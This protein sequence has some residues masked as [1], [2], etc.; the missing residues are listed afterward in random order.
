MPSKFAGRPARPCRAHPV[1]IHYV[2]RLGGISC[3][4]CVPIA[5]TAASGTAGGG[6]GTPTTPTPAAWLMADLGVWVEC[7][8]FGGLANTIPKAANTIP[9][10]PD[11]IPSTSEAI[12]VDVDRSNP[13]APPAAMVIVSTKLDWFLAAP[14]STWA[15]TAFELT[16]P[17][18][19]SG[20]RL[21][22]GFYQRLT[23]DLF[24]WMVAQVNR[25]ASAD[26]NDDGIAEAQD[27]WQRLQEIANAAVECGVLGEWA[28][29][30]GA[31]PI[32]APSGFVPLLPARWSWAGV[33]ERAWPTEQPCTEVA[34]SK[35][36]G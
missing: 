25:M 35:A 22:L 30:A 4:A 9:N 26:L 3:A 21:P 5:T 28:L 10:G 11:T 12:P 23:P 32:E 36:C 24:S 7:D 34:I 27:S 18:T 14:Y 1:G 31:W 16:G 29:D 20:Q 2:N 13:T 33:V 6:G 15:E 8:E 19:L 17:T